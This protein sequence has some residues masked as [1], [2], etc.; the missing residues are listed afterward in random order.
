VPHAPPPTLLTLGRIL[1]PP[2][3]IAGANPKA[4]LLPDFPATISKKTKSLPDFRQA[5]DEE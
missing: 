5:P 4:P 3:K 1:F 2:L